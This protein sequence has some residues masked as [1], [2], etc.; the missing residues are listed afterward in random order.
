[1]KTVLVLV[2]I[3]VIAGG[4]FW[5][6]NAE[7]AVG[8]LNIYEG[9]VDVVRG[10]NGSAG[11]TGTGVKNND[12]IKVG[13]GSRVSIILKDGS[14]IRLEAGSEVEVLGAGKFKL[15]QGKMWSKVEPQ[16]V[17]WEVETPTIVAA[18]RGTAFNTRYSN[19]SSGVSVYDG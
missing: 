15:I 8:N 1:M 10:G 19:L 2:L 7:A 12:V 9:T 6:R 18:V 5:Y 11:K 17:T 13:T 4:L 14:V 16:S 3:A